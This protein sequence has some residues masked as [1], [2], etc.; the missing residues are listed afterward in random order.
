MECL[1]N[2]RIDVNLENPY[3][4]IT[5]QIVISNGHDSL[6]AGSAVDDL[7]QANNAPPTSLTR[8]VFWVS[9]RSFWK[10]V[11]TILILSEIKLGRYQST[12]H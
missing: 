2:A 5:L 9:L 4:E 12:L 11:W 6:E 1:L 8:R 7:D 10:L 3:K